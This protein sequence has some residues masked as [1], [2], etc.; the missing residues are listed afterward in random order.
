MRDC[1]SARERDL[2]NGVALSHRSKIMHVQF[3]KT[4]EFVR[5]WFLHLDVAAT[6]RRSSQHQN[7][8]KRG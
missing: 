3:N 2:E 8:L 7:K 4:R 5:Y 6:N 1:V